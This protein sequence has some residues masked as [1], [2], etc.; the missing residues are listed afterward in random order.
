[1]GKTGCDV[2][3][4]LWLI[5]GIYTGGG[6]KAGCSKGAESKSRLQ[7]VTRVGE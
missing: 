1:V 3:A 6:V 4:I 5:S 2:R 7:P